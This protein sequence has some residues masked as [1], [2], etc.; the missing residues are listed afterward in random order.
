M[1]SITFLV[2]AKHNFILESLGMN[3]NDTSG[4]KGKVFIESEK[5]T[6]SQPICSKTCPMLQCIRPPVM[7]FG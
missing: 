4:R 2:V 6:I 1:L 3:F 7:D 5:L